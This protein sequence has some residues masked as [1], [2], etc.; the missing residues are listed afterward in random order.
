MT[1][2]PPG[3][4]ALGAARAAAGFEPEADGLPVPR[5]YRAVLA[6]ALG[7]VLA[8]LD[9]S[10][11]NVAL[12]TMARELHASAASSVWILSGY[13][14][15]IVATLLPLAALGERVGYRRVYMAG[16]LLFTASS[17][18]CALAPSL[19]WL[20]AARVLQ[21]FG[22]A[23]IMSVNGA[24]VRFTYPHALLGRGVGLNALVVSL[25]FAIGPSVAAFILFLGP[26]PWLFAV[27]LPVGLL[28]IAISMRSL[29]ASPLSPSPMNWRAAI[30]TAGSFALFFLSV[31]ALLRGQRPLVAGAG[32]LLALLCGVVLLR[33]ER[34]DPHPLIPVD[35]LR[36][37][38]F[39]LSVLSSMCAFTA[40][41]LTLVAM[42]FL[43]ETVLHRP[44][45]IVGIV[46]TAWPL[47]LGVVGLLAGRLSDRLPGAALGGIGM[48]LLSIGLAALAALSGPGGRDWLLAGGMTL[49]GI[50]FGLFQ[51]PNNRILL[52]SGP[53]HRTGAAAGMLATGRLLGM[54]AGAILATVCFHLVPA[55]APRWD[56]V[57][58]A[59]L[60]LLAAV[61]SL[62]R[63]SRRAA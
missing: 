49:G 43:L 35:L 37:P 32:V 50:G 36:I 47:A 27:N 48:V 18:L 13:Q 30:L 1:A 22:A 61:S 8:V 11:V 12:P 7:I 52:S 44:T 14:L 23:G 10:V 33:L 57:I 56:F 4:A 55:H 42:P 54:T 39:R 34:E 38:V 63:L 51:S 3:S 6:I 2:A 26:W 31:G 59:A 19:S 28:A 41:M 17:L 29:P 40:Q 15:A 46:M 9:T 45:T 53:R 5:R 16:L 62:Q 24:L 60:A 21:G 20:V 25:A 58:G